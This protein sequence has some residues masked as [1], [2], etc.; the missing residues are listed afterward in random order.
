MTGR[1]KIVAVVGAA[2]PSDLLLEAALRIGRGLVDGGV[3][4]ATGGRGGV[5]AAASQGARSSTAWT[6]GTVVGVLPG[7]DASDANPFVDIV[8]PTGLSHAR[9]VVLVAM[10]D[11]VVAVGGGAG[12]LSEI[13][14]AW[15]HGKPIVGLDLGEG[16]SARLAGQALDARERGPVQRATSAEEAVMLALRLASVRSEGVPEMD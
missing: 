3:R 11:V 9:N 5:M 7:L 1:R 2:T 10:A 15:S 12:T 16:W 14:L 8:V 6:E 13:S 4:I